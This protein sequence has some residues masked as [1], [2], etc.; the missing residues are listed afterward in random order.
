MNRR[1]FL[2]DAAYAA[3]GLVGLMSLGLSF[4]EANFI[5][6]LKTVAKKKSTPA[7]CEVQQQIEDGGV[8]GYIGV[9]KYSTRLKI[10]TQFVY[11]G[12]DGKSICQANLWVNGLGTTTLTYNVDIFTDSAGMPSASLGS[13]DLYDSTGLTSS[14][15]KISF[16]FS[17]ST[18]ALTNGTTY[19]VVLYTA[20]AADSSNHVQWAYDEGTAGTKR[21][22][23]WDGSNW[24]E[25]S[26]TYT[27]KFE[28]VST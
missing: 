1:Q 5:N 2:I 21:V 26:T 23:R 16:P 14:E 12:T 10:G 7:V 3:G 11:G 22:T 6:Q 28:L 24:V 20:G 8:D 25:Y 4:A 27:M 18:S 13:S 15:T 19:H 17:S 9:G